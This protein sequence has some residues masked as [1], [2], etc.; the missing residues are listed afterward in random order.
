MT[1]FCVWK[2]FCKFYCTCNEIIEQNSLDESSLK[3]MSS[4][5]DELKTLYSSDPTKDPTELNFMPIFRECTDLAIYIEHYESFITGRN[6][7]DE[8]LWLFD[9]KDDCTFKLINGKYIKSETQKYDRFM[10]Y[11]SS[12]KF[13]EFTSGIA[14]W[15][16]LNDEQKHIIWCAITRQYPLKI[17]KTHSTADIATLL[18]E[19]HWHYP[20]SYHRQFIEIFM[21]DTC[22][23]ENAMTIASFAI[24]YDIRN[25]ENEDIRSQI[26][27]VKESEMISQ[28]CCLQ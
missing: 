12:Y 4:K 15:K 26:D 7:P 25:G 17:G 16:T 9:N 11:I 3:I 1:I 27:K 23:L 18:H 21:I 22:S 14:H 19:M 8:P 20:Y 5:L 10:G 2:R 13:K 28:E 24:K 6:F